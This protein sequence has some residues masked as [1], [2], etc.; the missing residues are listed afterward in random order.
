MARTLAPA[1]VQGS[2]GG[3]KRNRE[4]SETLVGTECD[5]KGLQLVPVPDLFEDH[6]VRRAA[7]FPCPLEDADG[8]EAKC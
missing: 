1:P 8:H 3:G 4:V 6:P 5:G 2:S 7:T